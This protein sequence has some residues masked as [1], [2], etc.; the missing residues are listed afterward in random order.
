MGTRLKGKTMTSAFCTAFRGCYVGCICTTTTL[1]QLRCILKTTGWIFKR[2]LQ[3][4]AAW[5]KFFAEPDK[6]MGGRLS[7][8]ACACRH[9]RPLY[10]YISVRQ[11][12]SSRLLVLVRVRP[13]VKM[14]TSAAGI[15]I[16]G[17]RNLTTSASHLWS[18]QMTFVSTNPFH[19]FHDCMNE[20]ENFF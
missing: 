15:G 7:W 11:S 16:G 8:K 1:I 17:S 3:L 2:S 20:L 12:R 19:G 6:L 18:F 5:R 9:S 13:T 14:V 10:V 4:L